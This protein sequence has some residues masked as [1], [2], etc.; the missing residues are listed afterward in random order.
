[1]PS[2][3]TPRRPAGRPRRRRPR[4]R[5]GVRSARHRHPLGGDLR[6]VVAHEPLVHLLLVIEGPVAAGELEFVAVLE[7]GGNHRLECRGDDGGRLGVGRARLDRHGGCHE[8]GRHVAVRQGAVAIDEPPVGAR[9]VDPRVHRPVGCDRGLRRH[10]RG[11]RREGV[12]RCQP[13]PGVVAGRSEPGERTRSWQQRPPA[14]AQPRLGARRGGGG[15]SGWRL[16]K[17]APAGRCSTRSFP[18][19]RFDGRGNTGQEGSGDLA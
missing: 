9:L 15:P 7:C 3:R 14:I 10:C 17:G 2:R 13:R 8:L 6:A 4:D 11:G 12:I 5:S 18:A 16:V 19:A 1:M